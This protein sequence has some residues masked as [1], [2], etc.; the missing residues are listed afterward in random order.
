[1]KSYE[2]DGTDGHGKAF[3]SKMKEV[4]QMTGLDISV[5]HT[6]NDEV[7]SYRQ[8]VWLCNGPC[9]KK[10][11]Y[12]GIVKRQVNRAPSP[13]DDWCKYFKIKISYT[14]PLHLKNCGGQFIKIAEPEGYVDKN[15]VKKKEPIVV[16]TLDK[17]F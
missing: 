4:N 15:K 8:H 9:K 3:Q 6:F 11:P 14:V 1:M 5:Y 2:R 13:L 17:Y 7:E 12:Y 10:H 16:G